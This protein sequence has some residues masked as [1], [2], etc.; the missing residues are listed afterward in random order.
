MRSSLLKSSNDIKSYE[1]ESSLSKS[2]PR[3]NP[4]LKKRL[5][6]LIE[7]ATVGRFDT[8][9]NFCKC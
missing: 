2:N 9:L 3:L 6:A 5:D 4:K 8:G 7:E 1:I